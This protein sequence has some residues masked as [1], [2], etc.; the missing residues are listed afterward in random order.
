M[1]RSSRFETFLENFKLSRL[2]PIVDHPQN[3]VGITGILGNF[4]CPAE[5]AH[6]TT[7]E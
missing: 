1:H 4:H 2:A 5:S 3:S 7:I 6:A